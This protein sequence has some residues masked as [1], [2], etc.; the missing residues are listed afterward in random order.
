MPERRPASRE[1]K[2]SGAPRPQPSRRGLFRFGAGALGA[3]AFGGATGCSASGR[4]SERLDFWHPLSGADGER[5][6]ELVQGYNRK[7]GGADF[8]QTVLSWGE[9]YYT[10]L[11]MS[12]AGG[13]APALAVMHAT[14]VPGYTQG[15]LLDSWDAELFAEL[16]VTEEDFPERI[17]RKGV[18]DGDLRSIALDT[19]PFVLHYNREIAEAAGVLNADGL[20]TEAQ[21]P[22]EFREIAARMKE[23]TDGG[24]GISFGY[25]NDFAQM[26][27]MFYTFYSQLGGTIELPQGKKMRYDEDLAV[28]ALEWIRSLIDGELGSNSHDGGTA[29]SEFATGR[30]GMLFSGVWDLVGLQNEG[31]PFD[32]AIIPGVFGRTVAYGDSHTFVLPHQ[33]D[34]DPQERRFVHEFVASILKR[35]LDWAKAGHI[36]AYSPVTETRQYADLVPQSHYSDAVDYLVYDP[37]AWFS[38]TATDFQTYFG[39]SIQQ[40]LSGNVPP[41]KGLRAF[42]NRIDNL[43]SRPSPV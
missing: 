43:L 8:R 4:T 6:M 31:V 38:G 40:V 15:R 41:V 2:T 3:L 34:P 10:K 39:D 19:H 20:L 5:M 13:R 36:P 24:Q 18:I 33:D 17:W 1:P 27:R 23:A 42:A 26:W 14:R 11:A 9:P 12:S 22:E 30:S 28:R 37:E 35:S 16:G 32:T 7:S 29:Y 25:L 21:S